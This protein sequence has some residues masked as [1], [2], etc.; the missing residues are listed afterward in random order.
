MSD[1]SKGTEELSYW[2][3]RHVKTLENTLRYG[4]SEFWGSMPFI[5]STYDRYKRAL[6]YEALAYFIRS[7]DPILDEKMERAALIRNQEMKFGLFMG[8]ASGLCF[9]LLPALKGFN[10]YTR[11]FYFL[12][13]FSLSYYRG[14]RRGYDQINYVGETY[15]E[16]LLKQKVFL[17]F[18]GETQ[19]YLAELK[20]LCMND[21]EVVR[22]MKLYGVKPYY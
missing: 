5:G 4:Y 1:S 13:P 10:I 2:E 20:E 21:P 11:L 18:V 19:D 6:T 15:V 3:A 17:N 8:T 7:G 16:L 12:V 14:F 22:K 9:S